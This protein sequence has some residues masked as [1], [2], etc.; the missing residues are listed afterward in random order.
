MVC[1]VRDYGAA[2]RAAGPRLW[3]LHACE[4]DRGAPG[5]GIV[6]WAAVFAALREIAFDGPLVMES[7]N[8]AIPGFAEGRGMLH[9]ICPD[10]A[11]FV[12]SG[13]DF[14]KRGLEV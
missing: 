6:P 7:Y 5:G 4:N 3:G 12:R 1:E 11:E 10:A 9:N 14:L 2:V 8:S 13:L